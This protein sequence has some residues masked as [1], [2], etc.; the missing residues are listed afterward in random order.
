[1]NGR[2][3]IFD[4]LASLIPSGN[5]K[6]KVVPSKEKKPE[7]A[8]PIENT[9]QLLGLSSVAKELIGFLQKDEL[10]VRAKANGE[11]KLTYE[12]MPFLSEVSPAETIAL[13]VQNS[14]EADMTAL[15]I[16]S[17]SAA[18]TKQVQDY[19]VV[20]KTAIAIANKL[21]AAVLRI[22]LAVVKPKKDRI[23]K[24][25]IQLA[26][27][28]DVPSIFPEDL[29]TVISDKK[30]LS[31][32]DAYGELFAVVTK[33]LN[34]LNNVHCEIAQYVKPESSNMQIKHLLQLPSLPPSP[35]ADLPQ[36]PGV[37]VTPPKKYVTPMTPAGALILPFVKDPSPLALAVSESAME[38]DKAILDQLP[39]AVLPSSDAPKPQVRSLRMGSSQ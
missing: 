21:L 28:T 30:W 6:A 18:Q 12:P 34:D 22:Q 39:G 4:F 13:H 9:A 23:P 11:S 33:Y 20:A 38:T 32:E 14:I 37:V 35:P 26:E 7:E 15:N 19:F 8:K 1:M 3:K 27:L 17:A 16:A 2:G 24:I 25:A 29:H 10:G 31:S 5:K 36:F